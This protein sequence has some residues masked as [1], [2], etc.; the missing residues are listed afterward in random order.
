[1]L[2]G[3]RGE[4]ASAADLDCH[5]LV[6]ERGASL[7]RGRS[8]LRLSGE[9]VLLLARDAVLH[10]DVLGGHAHVDVVERVG[11]HHDGAVDEGP[12]AEFVAA[13]GAEVVEG[14]A[15]HGLVASG[16]YEVEVV[17]A[18]LHRGGPDRLQA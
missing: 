5:D 15:G 18:H 3:V 16:E 7:G 9:L 11:Q 10:G 4:R 13:A 8:T 17:P 12:V 2:V 6:R 1:M 14:H